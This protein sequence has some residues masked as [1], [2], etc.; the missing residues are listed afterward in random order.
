[1][2]ATEEF[3][4][5]RNGKIIHSVQP[6]SGKEYNHICSLESL[7]QVVFFIEKLEGGFTTGNL[8]ESLS[9]PKTQASVA[10]AFLKEF[11]LV[12][13]DRN[14]CYKSPTDIF[15]AAMCE[16]HFLKEGLSH[17]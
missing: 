9:I 17:E 12:E 5:N 4:V 1:M 15:L 7:K 16:Y 14:R 8:W 11:G 3:T 13:V 2:K 10:L 6:K